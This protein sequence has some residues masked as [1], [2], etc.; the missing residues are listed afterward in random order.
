MKK[1][2]NR[3]KNVNITFNTLMIYTTLYHTYLLLYCKGHIQMISHYKIIDVETEKNRVKNVNVTFNT[4]KIYT[5]L[6]D[7]YL[8]LYCKGHIQITSNY[9][10]EDMETEKKYK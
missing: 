8:L 6:Y 3:V 7:T 5:T 1:E 2:N 10:I 4:L 9:S